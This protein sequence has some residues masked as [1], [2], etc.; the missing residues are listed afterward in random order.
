MSAEKSKA[1]GAFRAIT[2][3]ILGMG[4]LLCSLSFVLADFQFQRDL[5]SRTKEVNSENLNQAL[6][7]EQNL[8]RSFAQADAILQ[9]VKTEMETDG[10]LNTTYV[11]LLKDFLKPGMFNQITVADSRGNLV[12][13]AVPLMAPINIY[14]REHFQTHLNANSGNMY[15]S[16]PVVNRAAGVTSIFLSRRLNDVNGNFVGIV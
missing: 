7:L 5:E 4:I 9:L 3:L 1:T 2:L 12:Y 15:I 10:S 11:G 16:V 14:D 13:S 8:N 6:S